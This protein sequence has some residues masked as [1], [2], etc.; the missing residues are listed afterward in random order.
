MSVKKIVILFSGE[1]SNLENLIKTLHPQKVE[2]VSAITNNPKAKGIQKAENLGVDVIIL[3]HKEYEN[4]EDFDAKMVEVIKKLDID[5]VV[6]AGFMRILTPIFT[7]NLKAIN[8]HPSLLPLFKGANAI[9]QSFYS[10]MK[11][12]G[13]SV[14]EVVSEVDGGNII[15]QRCFDKSQMDL[16]SFKKNIQIC[17]HE[18]FPKAVLDYTKSNN[19]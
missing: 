7:D 12:A 6:M 11:V 9:E 1:G 4:R 13:V 5:L 14:H 3:N 8:I 18:I 17:E 2:V 16:D 15:S 10:D 19:N